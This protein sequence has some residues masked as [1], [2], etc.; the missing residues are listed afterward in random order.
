ME[1]S[2]LEIVI[3]DGVHHVTKMEVDPFLGLQN[4]GEN[5]CARRTPIFRGLS[6][7]AHRG[8]NPEAAHIPAGGDLRNPSGASLHQQPAEFRKTESDERSPTKHSMLL[9]CPLKSV[10]H[11]SRAPG[12]A[13]LWIQP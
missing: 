1:P 11:L 13:I 6:G 9:G 12:T 5:A 10:P 3:G 7:T 4:I 2:P 8:G